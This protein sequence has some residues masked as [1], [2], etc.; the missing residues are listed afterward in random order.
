MQDAV[1]KGQQLFRFSWKWRRRSPIKLMERT[2][3]EARKQYMPEEK[4]AIL[5][6]HLLEKAVSAELFGHSSSNFP[7]A[8]VN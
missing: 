8:R 2:H 6:R 3:E 4:A 1:R 7:I 5:R